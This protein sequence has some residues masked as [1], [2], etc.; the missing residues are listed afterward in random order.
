MA[1]IEIKSW[2]DLIQQIQLPENVNNDYVWDGEMIIDEIELQVPNNWD[3]CTYYCYGKG[4]DFRGLKIGR[5]RTFCDENGRNFIDNDGSSVEVPA[6]EKEYYEANAW[7]NGFCVFGIV[8]TGTAVIQNLVVE[9][10]ELENPRDI[11]LGIDYTRTTSRPLYFKCVYIFDIY[12]PSASRDSLWLQYSGNSTQND[13]SISGYSTS[14]SGYYV[15]KFRAVSAYLLRPD[16][17]RITYIRMTSSS[18]IIPQRQQKASMGLS[19]SWQFWYC[20]INI[21]TSNAGIFFPSCGYWGCD[22]NFQ[23]RLDWKKKEIGPE[24][25]EQD[26]EDEEE[27][28]IFSHLCLFPAPTFDMGVCTFKANVTLDSDMDFG[29]SDMMYCDG[30]VVPVKATAWKY[31]RPQ[32]MQLGTSLVFDIAINNVNNTCN[33]IE[34]PDFSFDDR[35]WNP[36]TPKESIIFVTNHGYHWQTVPESIGELLLD[37]KNV[38]IL[39]AH[40]MGVV[41][42][43]GDRWLKYYT[44]EN[45][46][47]ESTRRKIHQLTNDGYPFLPFWYYPYEPDPDPKGKPEY[48]YI[49][50]FDMQTK[51]DKFEDNGL[52]ILT[53]TSC[54]VTEELNG[55]WNVIL[56]HPKDPENRWR[57]ILEMN[58]L[59]VLGQLFIIR[60][61]TVRNAANSQSVTAYAEHIS[62]HLNDYWLFPG[63][64]IAAYTGEG[65]IKSIQRQMYDGDPEKSSW[66]TRYTFQ[67]ESDLDS[68]E[69][70]KEWYDMPEGHTAYEMLIG[71]NGFTSLV[72]GELYRDNFY[73]SINERME[74]SDD[75]AFELHP[76]LNLKAIEKTVDLQTFCTYFKAYDQYGG[77]WAVSW[78]PSTMP[79]RYPHNV[80]RSQNFTFDVD[81]EYYSFAMLERKGQDFFKRNCAPLVSFKIQVQDLK[82]HPDYKNFTNNY[83][84]KVGDIGKIWDED[85]QRYYELEVTKTVHDGIT[86]ECIEVVIGTER[87]FTRPASYPITLDRNYKWD[88]IDEYDP[89]NP[90]D[91]PEPPYEPTTIDDY[92]YT[93]SEDAIT[94]ILYTGSETRVLVPAVDGNNKPVKYIKSSCFDGNFKL[95][96]VTVPENIE[97]IE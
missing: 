62:Y 15:K 83:R 82:H 29:I 28:E 92:I 49:C 24:D 35:L 12:A 60:K 87:S 21:T 26:L 63:T 40:D 2:S 39:A 58:I 59:K 16:D 70:L 22:L 33:I 50:V 42:D 97:V 69:D 94:L 71:N 19:A 73:M 44:P 34:N 13:R 86:G 27:P 10:I 1:T 46:I 14:E 56:V 18:P 96:A 64:S 95:E 52:A 25:E 67:I 80:V 8:G 57:Y 88:V 43:D 90:P 5:I 76:A 72:G 3:E 66:Q 77:W 11:L 51:Q 78:D 4:I 74:F 17:V 6:D 91:P 47:G 20:C 23:Y 7:L 9:H 65:I 37:L 81:P 68:I 38:D 32:W 30:R 54:R 36:S 93:E 79:R 53:P 48:N 89:D 55:G 31:D 41:E 85:E 75:N 61:V 45:K 84:F